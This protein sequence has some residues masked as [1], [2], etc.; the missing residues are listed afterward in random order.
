MHPNRKENM[1]YLANAILTR[2][3]AA[4][5]CQI[6]STQLPRRLGGRYRARENNYDSTRSSYRINRVHNGSLHEWSTKRYL[7]VDD[8]PP[9]KSFL[10]EPSSKSPGGIPG[11]PTTTNVTS[12]ASVVLGLQ[13]L[14]LSSADQRRVLQPWWHKIVEIHRVILQRQA[15]NFSQQRMNHD[16]ENEGA[17]DESS[18]IRDKDYERATSNE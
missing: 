1:S 2:F 11:T 13:H 16:L 14:L 15:S 18:D 3:P 8:A 6:P 4:R 5:S 12:F 9:R 17:E 10:S 7:V